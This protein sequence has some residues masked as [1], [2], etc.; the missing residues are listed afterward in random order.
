MTSFTKQKK[1]V[2]DGRCQITQNNFQCQKVV[3]TLKLKVSMNQPNFTSNIKF[4][5]R[6]SKTSQNS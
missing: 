1:N 2:D 6:V 5:P 4:Q 3:L